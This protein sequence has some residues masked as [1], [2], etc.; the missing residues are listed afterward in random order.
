MIVTAELSLYPITD[1]YDIH[2][3]SFVKRLH[4]YSQ[5]SV[6]TNA[7]STYVQGDIDEVMRILSHELKAIYGK[8]DMAVTTI[9]IVNRQLPITLP[10]ATLNFR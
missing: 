2:I 5:L 8:I 7:M 10:K 4:D 6:V 9:K 3:L 1:E